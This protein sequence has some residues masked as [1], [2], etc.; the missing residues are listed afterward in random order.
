M[1]QKNRIWRR[2]IHNMW[3]QIAVTD[4]DIGIVEDQSTQEIC[5]TKKEEEQL[6]FCDIELNN[7]TQ[8]VKRKADEYQEDDDTTTTKRKGRRYLLNIA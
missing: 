4:G 8:A 6:A 3:E 1:A 7:T 5:E 2:I